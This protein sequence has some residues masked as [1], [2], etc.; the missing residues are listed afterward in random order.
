MFKKG[1]L[2]VICLLLSGCEG[3]IELLDY[4][5]P[6]ETTYHTP[7]MG[8]QSAHY[9][10]RVS[11]HYLKSWRGSHYFVGFGPTREAA[12]EKAQSKCMTRTG[13]NVYQCPI[14]VVERTMH[15]GSSRPIN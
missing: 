6:R 2:L 14:D 10:C 9:K 1:L 15:W 8:E 12:C 7:R 5:G 3:A 4:V 13:S 11:V